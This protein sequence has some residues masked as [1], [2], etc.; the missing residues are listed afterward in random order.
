MLVK[1]TAKGT[2]TDQ[3]GFYSIELPFGTYIITFSAVG[4]RSQSRSVTFTDD[5]VL[6]LK[7]V[8]STQEL[9][10]VVVTGKTPDQNVKG[11]QMST[12]QL[13]IQT[14]NKIPAVLGEAD[15]IKAFTLQPGVTTVGEGAGGFNV[16]GGRV[17]QNLVLLDGAPV[18]NTSHLL[19]FF[20][21]VNPDVVREATLYKG[22]IPAPFGGR[23]S[24]LLDIHTKSGNEEQIR[25]SFGVGPISSRIIVDGPLIKNKVTFLAS[26]RVAYP[27]FILSLFPEQFKGNRAFY[28]DVNGKL[29]YKLNDNNT[30]ALSAYRSTDN[31]KFPEDTLYTWHSN[32]ASLHWNSALR[33]D[34]VLTVSGIHS[35]YKLGMEGLKEQY[36]F[37]LASSI[38]HQEVKTRLFYA[39]KSRHKLEAGANAI[40]YTLNPGSRKPLKNSIINPQTLQ[41]E[42]AREM[43]A[44]ISDEFLITPAITLQAGVRYSW[45]GNVGPR[46]VYS[47]TQGA[48]R[49]LEAIED[50]LDYQHGKF[51][52]TYGG[53]E[54]RVSL[55]VGFGTQTAVK[56]SYNRMRQYLHLISN[57]TAISPVDFW[58]V[59]DSYIP[60]QVVDQLAVGIFNNFKSNEIET[61]V[62]AFYKDITSLV[63]YKNGAVLLMNPIIETALLPASGKA[64]GIEVSLAKNKGK[65][66]GQLSYTYSRS[67]AKVQA[68]FATESVNEGAYFPS[69]YDKPHNAALSSQL[70]L[71][72]GWTFSTNFVYST[73]R[74]I[75]YPDGQYVFNNTPVIDYSK[76]NLDRLPDY[77]RLDIS[78]TKDTRVKKDQKRYSTWI[79]S[80]YNVYSRKNPYSIYFSK[81][82]TV[83][84]AYQLSV[85]GSFIPS[86]TL[87]FYF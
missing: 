12:I 38:K 6:D 26:G 30:I 34:L 53:W 60:P 27:N 17:D 46:Q 58:K 68:D 2:V 9:Q 15:I 85:L 70:L 69:T 39:L 87:N 72:R 48:P 57:T 4:Y 65:L 54:P 63:E 56:F 7:L 84:R 71:G 18:F 3:Q 33:K 24:S 23:L 75:T 77:H 86:L 45:F 1:N 51:I 42:F 22:G 44:Y 50:S 67:L 82:R 61:S 66:T 55:R 76:R 8:N 41:K 5:V 40:W 37:L 47:Y 13:N 16:R 43:A 74:P 36:Q 19:G 20:T 83:T 28:Y 31:F 49:T 81:V 62:E 73:G 35:D 29:Q 80:I 10:E 11:A 25:T 64:Y 14:L 59:S 52:K 21:S 79:F 32:L 78:F